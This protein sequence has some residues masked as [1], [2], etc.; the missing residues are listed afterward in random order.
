MAS[1]EAVLVDFERP[2]LMLKSGSWY[3]EFGGSPGWTVNPSAA[4][5][6]RSLNDLLLLRRKLPERFKA[7]AG[8]GRLSRK[9]A[10]ID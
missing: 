10:F 4:F 2:D 5:A 1:F 3:A 7:S 9:P 6:Q 8:N